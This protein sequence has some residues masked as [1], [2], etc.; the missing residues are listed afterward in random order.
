MG[1]VQHDFAGA[2]IH[3][4]EKVVM[5]GDAKRGEDAARDG[6]DEGLGAR[7]EGRASHDR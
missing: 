2:P 4:R 5:R 7:I 1:R 6:S 3:V